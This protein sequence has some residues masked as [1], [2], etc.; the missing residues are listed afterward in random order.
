MWSAF[1]Q[2]GFLV[3][4]DAILTPTAAAVASDPRII[5]LAF[6]VRTR[7]VVWNKLPDTRAS[8]T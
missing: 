7:L 4:Q 1:A 2:D 3:D 8:T 6:P 5:A